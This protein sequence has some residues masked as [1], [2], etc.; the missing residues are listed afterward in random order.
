[1]KDLRTEDVRC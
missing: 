1:V